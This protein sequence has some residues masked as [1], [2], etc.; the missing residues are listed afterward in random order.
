MGSQEAAAQA[1][2]PASWDR[3]V[4][5]EPELASIAAFLAAPEARALVVVGD[6]GIGKTTL[7]EAGLDAARAQGFRVLAT[8]A[9]EAEAR[10]SHLGLMDLLDG[11]DEAELAGLPA[12]QRYALEVA[13]LR[14]EPTG[15]PSESAIAL[16]LLNALR[17]LAR[18]PMLVAVDDVPWLDRPTADAL[19]FAARR[20]GGDGP[21]FLLARRP[22]RPS[23]LE[24]AFGEDGVRRLDVGP[25][26]YGAIRR[27]LATR[28][29]LVVPRHRLRRLVDTT[30]GNPLFALEVGRALADPVQRPDDDELPVPDAV[31]DLLGRR[32]A[33]LP[34]GT[35]RVLLATA[36]SADLTAF[37][38]AAIADVRAVEDA[39]TDGVLVVSGERVRASH[40][41][42][43]AAAR[44]RSRPATRRGLHL[45]LAGV[46]DDEE[47]RA[48]HLALA[49]EGT[50]QELATIVASAAAAAAA[51]G[52]AREAVDL[53]EHALRLTP[54]GSQARSDRVLAL[55]GYL[56]V[57][58][59]VQR[60]TDLLTPELG[61]LPAGAARVRAQL[62]L[63][64][65]GGVRSV[66]DHQ[67]HLEA[68]LAE[69]GGDPVLRAPVLAKWSIHATAACVERIPEA[70]AWALE[71]L[72]ATD[73]RDPE[74]TRLALHGLAW[75]RALGG[76][77]VDDLDERFVAESRAAFHLIDSV[78]RVAALRLTWRGEVA[79]ARRALARLLALADARGEQWS[80]VV[81]RLHLCELELRAGEWEHAERLLDEWA[82]SMEGELLVAPS[83]ERC[84]AALAA[85]RGQPDEVARWAAPALTGAEATGATWQL[86]G[87]MHARARSALLV[88]DHDR[89][90]ELSRVIWEHAEREGIEDPGALP[91]AADLVEAL[92]EI[93]ERE[94][95][96][97]VTDRLRQ[98]AEGQ[99]H[100]CGLITSRRCAALV[101]L[102]EG[103]YTPEAAATLVQTADDYAALGLRFDATRTLLVLGRAQRRHKKWAAARASLERAATMFDEL[104]STGWAADV[105]AELERVGARR[106]RA[107]GQLTPTERR[108]VELAAE[109]R[110]NKEIARTL[111]VT[112]NTVETHLSHAYAKLGIRS[113]AQLSRV[114]L[115]GH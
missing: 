76:K 66:A 10:M 106:P 2:A 103:P 97:T 28:L 5:R 59:D 86:L 41:L 108:V 112:V 101:A 105:R 23:A 16:G 24:R 89:A 64:E 20:L 56:D 111:V 34:P 87:T 70:E 48:R 67:R 37:Q 6:P 73:G 65:G 49:A 77:P 100:P 53:A 18:S 27:L 29:G 115:T 44:K 52:G 47:L 94:E 30:L 92:V 40:P 35:R 26:S 88:H 46:V 7:W 69:A 25:L 22:A 12:P 80:Y 78:E 54:V 55:A 96:R 114:D 3:V 13:L 98:L 43:A 51:R 74:V 104:G 99:A 109:G 63:S 15:P 31:D 45:E 107:A 17:S 32:V 91:A 60:I 14:T 79:A 36:L 42:L 90:A 95:A 102:A 39:V 38:L 1:A 33:R 21:R 62:L 9:S 57:A 8:R 68:A 85:G 83:Y 75:A 50:D 84:R 58:G 72:D 4:G 110:S 71:A 82:E 11:V 61:S 81:L 113:R 19:A 93:G